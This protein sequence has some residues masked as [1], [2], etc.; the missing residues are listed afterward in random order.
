MHCEFGGGPCK[1]NVELEK[2][3]FWI[4]HG[5]LFS[6]HSWALDSYGQY[7]Q[8]VTRAMSAL[9]NAGSSA[10]YGLNVMY[11]LESGMMSYPNGRD[12]MYMLDRP[13]LRVLA[14]LAEQAGADLRILLCRRN[15]YRILFSTVF[16]RKFSTLVREVQSLTDNA[17]A[18]YGQL[19]LI[20]R[21]FVYCVDPTGAVASLHTA[22]QHFKP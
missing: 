22:S 2:M 20:D 16:K 19:L 7:E 21:R 4:G 10:L 14:E 3:L 17:Y 15:S 9:V 12:P 8:N 11:Y 1:K 13:D 18:L 6:A 5:G